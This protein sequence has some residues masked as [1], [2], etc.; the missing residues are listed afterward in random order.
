MANNGS[1]HSADFRNP[2]L[3]LEGTEQEP[4][5][6]LNTQQNSGWDLPILWGELEYL[7]YFPFDEVSD[8]ENMAKVKEQGFVKSG[9]GW[10]HEPSGITGNLPIPLKKEGGALMHVN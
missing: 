3:Y 5:S 8:A 4:A 1:L 9:H 2:T 10:L 6:L 7:N